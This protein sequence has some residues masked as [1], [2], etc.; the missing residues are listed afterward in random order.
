MSYNNIF[1]APVSVVAIVMLRE[2]F[3]EAHKAREALLAGLCPR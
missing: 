3:E 1:Q 2:A